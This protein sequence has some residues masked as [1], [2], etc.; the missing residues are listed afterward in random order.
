MFGARDNA[1]NK[2]IRDPEN[3]YILYI[4][5]TVYALKLEK[6]YKTLKR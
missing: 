3:L 6:T 5:Y 2:H 1:K 4:I